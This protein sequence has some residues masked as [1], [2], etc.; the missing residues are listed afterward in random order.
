LDSIFEKQ[1]VK[2]QDI[3]VQVADQET[4]DL[5]KAVNFALSKGFKKV[6]ILGATGKREDHTIGNISLLVNYAK[7]MEV[8]M[9][10]DYGIWTPALESRTFKS[11]KGQ[12]VSIYTFHPEV[13]LISENLKYP[14]NEYKIKY[15]WEGTLNESLQDSFHLNFSGEI[16][17]F[18]TH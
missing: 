14:L 16:I 2:Y 10:S 11:Y 7:S 1:K 13:K 12:Q 8:I 15:W 6:T 17:V 18:Q 4:N 5:T 9:V 3:I